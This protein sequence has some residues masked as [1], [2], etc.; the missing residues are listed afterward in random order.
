MKQVLHLITKEEDVLSANVIAT[1]RQSSDLNVEV[2]DLSKG[3]PDYKQL[4]EKIFAAD[5]VAVW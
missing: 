3:E 1:Q 5:S 4:V 2:L